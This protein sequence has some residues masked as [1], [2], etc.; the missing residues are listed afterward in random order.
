MVVPPPAAEA[1]PARQGVYLAV[2]SAAL[3]PTAFRLAQQVRARGVVAVMDPEGKSLKA[4]LREADK[5]QC[6]FVAILG[7]KESQAQALSV[8]DLEQGSQEAIAFDAFPEAMA[9]HAVHTHI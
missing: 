3:M 2:L 4:Q 1:A 7:D 5:W 8:K 6:R 9:Q